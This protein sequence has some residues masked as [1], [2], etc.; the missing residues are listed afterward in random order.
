MEPNN[1]LAR[2]APGEILAGLNLAL[3]AEYQA[4]LDYR[5][6]AQGSDR[7]DLREALE[8]VA[9]VE[10]EHALRL[11]QRIMALGGQ[12]ATHPLQPHP[13]GPLARSGLEHDLRGEQWAIVE[14]A[15]LVAATLDDDTTADL[16]A[17]LLW[18][19]IQHAAWLRATLRAWQP[20]V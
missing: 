17:E 19:E 20:E 10:E 13:V 7:D 4:A 11:A 16:L 18:D 14:Y 3:Q 5:A 2:L 12:L 8:S 6:H 9:E 1:N 15:R